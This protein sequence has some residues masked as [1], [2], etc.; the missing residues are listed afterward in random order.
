MET[1]KAVLKRYIDLDELEY[2]L[3]TLKFLRKKLD[4]FTIDIFRKVVIENRNQRGLIKA[5][6]EDY[7]GM[8]KKYDS[9]VLILEAQGF[10]EK[11]EDG[12]ATPYYVTIRGQQLGTLLS[13]EKRKTLEEE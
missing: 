6:L 8:R 9:A 10:I 13:D 3:N 5:R 12:T 11:K 2:D 4:E 7:H 1:E